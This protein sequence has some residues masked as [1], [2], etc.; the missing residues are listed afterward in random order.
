MDKNATKPNQKQTKFLNS[1][2]K[3]LKLENG[4]FYHLRVI[5]LCTTKISKKLK[6]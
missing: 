1:T 2:I 3:S 5:G 6:K 4:L